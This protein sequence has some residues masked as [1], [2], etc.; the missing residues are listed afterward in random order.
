[1]DICL[2]CNQQF[3]VFTSIDSPNDLNQI[4]GSPAIAEAT[5][6]VK[7]KTFN[8]KIVLPFILKCSESH[9]ICH[10]CI[11]KNDKQ[12]VKCPRCNI[13]S[14]LPE[15]KLDSASFL[16]N[17]K[18]NNKS[19]LQVERTVNELLTQHQSEENK[20]QIK[21]TISRFISR[22]CHCETKE[23]YAEIYCATCETIICRSCLQK[24]SG[25]KLLP[26][27][28]VDFEKLS[29]HYHKNAK[30]EMFCAK[31]KRF[32]CT[33]CLGPDGHIRHK[34]FIFYDSKIIKSK[35]MEME[36][37][38]SK[39]KIKNIQEQAL[40]N[41]TIKF[42]SKSDKSDDFQKTREISKKSYYV[43]ASSIVQP[44]NL[45]DSL[46]VQPAIVVNEKNFIVTPQL[47]PIPKSN[48]S[49]STDI[50]QR[51][52]PPKRLS[53][54][55]K[56]RQEVEHNLPKP[57]PCPKKAD[58]NNNPKYELFNANEFNDKGP[59]EFKLCKFASPGEIWLV[60]GLRVKLMDKMNAKHKR[61]ESQLLYNEEE[62]Q[63]IPLGEMIG[64]KNDKSDLIYRARILNKI[65][66]EDGSLLF[67]V[68]GVDN[69]KRLT[70]KS[71]RLRKLIKDFIDIPDL[72]IKCSLYNLKP[73]GDENNC[74]E[75]EWNNLSSLIAKKWFADHQNYISLKI[76]SQIE[77]EYKVDFVV[78]WPLDSK[79]ITVAGL[80]NLSPSYLSD[81]LVKYKLAVRETNEEFSFFKRSLKQPHFIPMMAL[82]PGDQVKATISCFNTLNG[83]YLK[84]NYEDDPED[85]LSKRLYQQINHE[86][87]S[88]SYNYSII[89]PEENL[90]VAAQYHDKNWYRA[91]I[92]KIYPLE[93][94]VDVFFV[95]YGES[96]TLD[97]SQVCYLKYDF[98]VS[99]VS[100]FKC[101]L[102]GI[103]FPNESSYES[104][105]EHVHQIMNDLV[106]SEN[107][108]V[109][110]IVKNVL[111]EEKTKIYEVVLRYRTAGKLEN[112]NVMLTKLGFAECTN[113]SIYDGEKEIPKTKDKH[114]L[115]RVRRATK[116][117]K[118]AQKVAFYSAKVQNFK[119]DNAV[120]CKVL[121][122][123]S[124][125]E[126]WVQD[127][128]DSDQI[129]EKFHSNLN[130]HYISLT[131]AENFT[132]S[133]VT[134]NVGDLCVMKKANRDE[135]HRVQVTEKSDNKY[136]LICVDIGQY[137]IADEL[138][139]FELEKDYAQ[140]GFMAK[141]CFI[142]GIM[143]TGTSDGQWSSLANEFTSSSL[144]DQYVYVVF[145]ATNDQKHE[146]C[147]YVSASRKLAM[148]SEPSDAKYVKFSDVLNTE[149]L[150]LIS[151]KNKT[152][153]KLITESNLLSKCGKVC[154]GCYGYPDLPQKVYKNFQ[155]NFQVF[156]DCLVTEVGHT[157][158]RYYVW[159]MFPTMVNSLDSCRQMSD[160]FEIFYTKNSPNFSLDYLM[161]ALKG[162]RCEACV[163]RVESAWYRGEIL[164]HVARDS[165]NNGNFMV[166][167]IDTGRCEIIDV[168][169]I[170][171]PLE[172]FIEVDRLVYQINLE[173]DEIALDNQ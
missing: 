46:L 99:E 62:A 37:L 47:S 132:K 73:Y 21:E 59:I 49:N 98:L 96:Y 54:K 29:C 95:D 134:F 19:I 169:S 39:L 33:R 61:F 87:Q 171:K 158:N 143:P 153:D 75:N 16:L 101:R 58:E 142:S 77:N 118:S 10:S 170:F 72:K 172:K 146:V 32:I 103:E 122:A 115:Q 23:N 140:P 154:T 157:N 88:N 166:R 69:C 119:P 114:I 41:E 106:G 42:V 160:T 123:D 137:E 60:P 74:L 22:C 139:L 3:G 67:D 65:E 84:L 100:T 64:Y 26:L 7:I 121:S 57:A 91:E 35:L 111:Q 30:A 25:H 148:N 161:S 1:M 93:A 38:C 120:L 141:Q 4:E 86:Y 144:K 138:N 163:C 110:L 155:N 2:N 127:V 112:L 126:L 43:K 63:N 9:R 173:T 27:G 105:N 12:K 152:I 102:F 76:I 51:L 117:E 85:Q 36:L 167:L 5:T 133:P 97:C 48:E 18:Q 13:K 156:Y 81:M 15:V 104:A 11:I 14:N 68:D 70:I 78:E 131:S 90:P 165:E 92:T 28:K 149:G 108:I 109:D 162:S 82:N 129:Y 124:P 44:N 136:K 20:K 130:H 8:N 135:F 6:T 31:E 107:K 80:Y 145:L 89:A 150:A 56:V 55:T 24:H 151:G 164:S 94:K 50:R 159:A 40:L 66:C 45:E 53:D 17:L 147:I 34:Y 79:A 83:F 52:Q 116:L 113:L 125:D 71:D 168:K 128:V